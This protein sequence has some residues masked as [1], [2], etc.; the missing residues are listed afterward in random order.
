M[1]NDVLTRFV[2]RSLGDC[3]RGASKIDHRYHLFSVGDTLSLEYSF[4]WNRVNI[5]NTREELRVNYQ[6]AECRRNGVA[7]KGGS[8][9]ESKNTHG[10]EK[11]FEYKG[12]HRNAP[13]TVH[14]PRLMRVSRKMLKFARCRMNSKQDPVCVSR[15]GNFLPAAFS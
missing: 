7:Q 6:C 14:F 8:P 13:D 10:M 9:C 3:F 1:Y 2:L 4:L 11:T 12:G 5:G 15:G